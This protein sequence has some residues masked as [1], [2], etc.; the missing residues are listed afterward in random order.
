MA[1][2][3]YACIF[4]LSP[5]AFSIAFDKKGRPFWRCLSCRHKVF[6][7]SALALF[8]V[9][10]AAKAI[11]QNLDEWRSSAMTAFSETLGGEATAARMYNLPSQADLVKAG[12]M[13]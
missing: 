12:V 11:G 10:R 7:Y 8:M 2:N 5:E 4:C 13:A 9:E 1:L 6:C 3:S